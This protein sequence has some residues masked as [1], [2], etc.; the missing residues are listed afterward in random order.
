VNHIGFTFGKTM[1]KNSALMIGWRYGM[2]EL[3]SP[4]SRACGFCCVYAFCC[5]GSL[6]RHKLGLF[7][8]TLFGLMIAGFG[9]PL[10]SQAQ[11]MNP[12]AAALSHE[13]E[14]A[15]ENA[16][17]QDIERGV[18]TEPANAP[19]I[20]TRALNTEVRRPIWF[21]GQSIRVSLHALGPAVYN[22]AL[23]ARV[24]CAAIGARPEA[25]LQIVR[26]AVQEA[27]PQVHPDIVG[28][29]TSCVPDPF[30]T[31]CVTR[32]RE[33]QS[34]VTEPKPDEGRNLTPA[35][36]KPDEEVWGYQP[37]DG[38]T[39]AEAILQSAI[40]AGSSASQYALSGSVDTVLENSLRPPTVI[41]NPEDPDTLITKWPT[42][43]PVVS[44]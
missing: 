6:W 39:L 11:E 33:A 20:V 40:D 2:H 1:S 21:A 35:E 28:A 17:F 26:V 15:R 44:P 10:E 43:P 3:I 23:V 27:P 18:R 32:I 7:W 5:I 9:L 24:I 13:S 31:V 14:G 37:C 4:A 22:H 25:A 19:A 8:P 41:G 16:A 38:P 34:A 29:A 30:N 36:P 42:P 12:A